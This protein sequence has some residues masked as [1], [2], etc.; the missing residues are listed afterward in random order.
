[1]MVFAFRHAKFYYERN[2]STFLFSLSCIRGYVESQIRTFK[3]WETLHEL[4][5]FIYIFNMNMTDGRLIAKY[6]CLPAQSCEGLAFLL[7]DILACT[8]IE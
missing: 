7:Y 4:I 2:L 3:E 6:F 5:A 1:M 8:E